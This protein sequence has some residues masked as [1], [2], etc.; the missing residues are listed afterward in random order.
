MRIPLEDPVGDISQFELLSVTL[1][2]EGHDD[3]LVPP[4]P[5]SP[6]VL[7]EGA[8]IRIKLIFRIGRPVEGLKFVA[9]RERQGSVVGITEVTL[10]CYRPGGPYEVV[11][12][13]ERLPSG[14]LARDT[15]QLRG[16]FVDADR[17]VLGEE[18]HSFR[19]AKE[20]L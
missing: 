14:H 9:G 3:P 17:H 8:E 19:I 12:P 11:L 10:G 20:W 18:S 16:T 15:Y 7:K 5:G 6:V 13:P 1:Y 4:L 2:A